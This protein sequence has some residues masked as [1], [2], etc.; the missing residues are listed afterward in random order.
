[1]AEKAMFPM[2]VL[3]V[4]QGYNTTY[5]HK[6]SYALDL[7]GPDA[8]VSKVYAPFS[9]TVQRIRDTNGEMWITSDEPVE[10][11]DGTVDYMTCLFIHANS[12]PVVNGQHFN[13]GDWIYNEGNKG[14][15]TG[16]HV[17]IECARGKFVAPYGYYNTGVYWY[18]GSASYAVWK[19]YNQVK[20]TDA[21]FI[22]DETTIM[23]AG[24][25]GA[26]GQ[27]L[28]W[29][30]AS[31]TVGGND[32]PANTFFTVTANN[33]QFMNSPDVNDTV[34]IVPGAY[35]PNGETFHAINQTTAGGFTWWKF[36][37]SD[38]NLYWCAMIEGRYTSEVAE[39]D[40]SN[41]LNLT[42]GNTQITVY[43]SVDLFDP[44]EEKLNAGTKR[45]LLGK[46]KKTWFG[47]TW[48]SYT[49]GG[50]TYYI[51][52]T[53]D[54]TVEEGPLLWEDLPP[55]YV[56][57]PLVGNVEHFNTP[58]VYDIAPDQYLQK[59]HQYTALQRSTEMIG[60]FIWIK[61]LYTD[62][63]QY[64]V[65]YEEAKMELGIRT[66]GPSGDYNTTKYGIDVSKYQG[67]INWPQVKA[68]AKGYQF[69]FIKCVSTAS[70]LYV[71]P[72][73]VYNVQNAQAQG[74]PTGAYIYTYATTQSYVDQEIN[75]AV[76][77]LQSYKMG[78]PIAWDCED[79][80][81][82][83]ALTPANLTTLVLY[84]LNKLKSLG[85]YPMLY[86]YTNFAN[87]YLEMSRIHA[88]GFDVWIAD[89]R[90]YCGYNGDYK[91]WQ[92]TSSGS[93]NGISGNVDC[94][95]S[96]WDYASYIADLG[97]NGY[98]GGSG[99]G[100]SIYPAT[101]MTGYHFEMLKGNVQYFTYPSIYDENWG[102]FPVGISVPI[103]SKLN[104]QY[105][106]FDFYTCTYNGNTVYVAYVDDGRMLLAEDVPAEFEVPYNHTVYSENNF[107]LECRNGHT[108][109]FDEPSVYA[110]TAKY[111]GMY[112]TCRLYARLTEKYGDFYFYAAVVDGEIWYIAI[113][114]NPSK[115][116]TYYGEPYQ[117]TDI[118]DG[119][120]FQV[121]TA[122]AYA[123]TYPNT[124]DTHTSLTVGGIYT[125]S[126]KLNLQ[127]NSMDWYVIDVNGVNMYAPVIEGAVNVGTAIS[128]TEV[129]V[130]SHLRINVAADD[131]Y[132]YKL[133]NTSSASTSIA[134]GSQIAPTAKLNQ[135]YQSMD[136]YVIMIDGEKWYLPI[137]DSVS[138][139][140][141]YTMTACDPN[142]KVTVTGTMESYAYASTGAPSKS[143]IGTWALGNRLND[144]IEEKTWFTIQD[145][146]GAVRYVYMDT[147]NGT[148][149]YQYATASVPGGAHMKSLD[150]SYVVYDHIPG[151]PETTNAVTTAIAKDTLLPIASQ[152]NEPTI[153]GVW[154]VATHNGQTV[155]CQD[156]NLSDI[157]YIY[158]ETPVDE[159]L[160][161]TVIKDNVKGYLYADLNCPGFSIIPKD[162]T[163][164]PDAYIENISGHN[165]YKVTFNAATLYICDDETEI[166]MSMQY[167]STVAIEGMYIIAGENSFAYRYPKAPDPEDKYL[168]DPGRKYPVCAVLDELLDGVQWVS[169]VF[170]SQYSIKNIDFDG[171]P[172]T[173]AKDV[174]EGTIVE[175]EA[176]EE[177]TE[178]AYVPIDELHEVT[179]Y[180][181]NTE[182][183]NGTV[184][185]ILVEDQFKFYNNPIDGKQV[186]LLQKGVYP[187]VAKLDNAYEGI[188][189][190]IISVDGVEYYAPLINGQSRVYVATE[191]EIKQEIERLNT[192]LHEIRELIDATL[193]QVSTIATRIQK[194][195]LRLLTL[196]LH[197]RT[198]QVAFFYFLSDPEDPDP[199]FPKE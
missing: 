123:T 171:D 83:S 82:A 156:T 36:R 13:Q 161:I 180:Y 158:T 157:V 89:Y 60:N 41:I 141:E 11:A 105:D 104:S 102:Y 155:Y 107:I 112:K 179:Y 59:D 40:D 47:Y 61:I 33:L 95:I 147:L 22:S 167:D 116:I 21:L 120:V 154:Y 72:Y 197:L 150:S 113:E 74:I 99:G 50:T 34:D 115:Y 177:N 159:H 160:V 5:S 51:P 151:N 199:L 176:P 90:G 128:Y 152:V 84:A 136:W 198:L 70:S 135:Q 127:Y 69:A 172:G 110:P 75:L 109:I 103:T 140:Y 31:Q 133:A 164:H 183:E 3:R 76:Q 169:I 181:P 44:V 67:S 100:G 165:W 190:Y 77:Q 175:D 148:F 132:A 129:S 143:L 58:D 88:A 174:P 53:S 10:W 15:V 79:N 20:V 194:V 62:D 192:E 173:V 142:Y 91:I 163:L 23:N 182:C 30:K 191:E 186:G 162:L 106:G 52:E 139:S 2:E 19:I 14:N 118:T 166:L 193:P 122:D 134:L 6:Q 137:T 68:D 86:T 195:K 92:Y 27:T 108:Q 37:Y 119:T 124:A 46:S 55:D 26:T 43:N 78:Y 25:D 48:Y 8:G 111:L 28:T 126:S 117:R 146:D 187:A 80:S 168:L 85:F 57:K 98:E 42:V 185:E 188:T 178:V 66:G 56:L 145:T 9:G 130:D 63:K 94:N 16:I 39:F 4:T 49:D 196:E 18:S 138:I 38:G 7:G 35:L 125:V 87:S 17:H 184:M 73:F 121:L 170:L 1:M 45:T 32:L 24:T 12:I 153:S 29:T 114:D 93:V 144:T 97:L 54:I 64:Y 81:L 189:W 131:V 101:P 149:S 96:Y 71:D 65:P